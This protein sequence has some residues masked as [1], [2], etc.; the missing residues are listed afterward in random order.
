VGAALMDGD[1]V[2]VRLMRGGSVA[3]GSE[4][5]YRISAL[6]GMSRGSMRFCGLTRATGIEAVL[7]EGD[8]GV[9]RDLA[10][11]TLH[12]MHREDDEAS[13]KAPPVASICLME[14]ERPSICLMEME[15]PS[16]CLMEME[17]PLEIEIS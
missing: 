9:G 4:E 5:E 7:V 12:V 6:Y 15:R 17:R 11:R 3:A 1:T 14:M 10:Q 8:G 16:I 2:V 13:I